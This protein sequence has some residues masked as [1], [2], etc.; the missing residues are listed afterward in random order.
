MTILAAS[1]IA[2]APATAATF[3]GPR[4]E[5]RAGWDRMTLD[6]SYH[7][8]A[9]RFSASGHR[10]GFDLGAEVGYDYQAGTALVVGGYAGIEGSSAKACTPIV[11]NDS[12]C[13]KLGR[14]FTVGARLGAAVSPL[15]MVY[16][17]GGYSNGQLR[18][19]Y[20]NGDDSTLNFTDHVNRGGYHFGLGGEVAVGAQGYVRAE[21]VRT[22]YNGEDYSDGDIGAS[23]DGHRDQGLVGFGIRF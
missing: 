16:V 9:D 4:A 22:N 10:S 18:A 13:L 7:D 19:T 6:L 11:G 8:G 1:A 15:I 2:A 20:E 21:Y 12:A 5:V 14:N 17:K 23:I 3:S